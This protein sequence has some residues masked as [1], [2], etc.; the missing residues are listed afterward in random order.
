M[1][2]DEIM[3]MADATI[4]NLKNKKEIEVAKARKEELL[5]HY[6]GAD[7][8][9]DSG[10][11]AKEIAELPPLEM[12]STGFSTLDKETEGGFSP[13]QL[14]TITGIA[15]QGKTTFMINLIQNMKSQNPLFFSLEQTPDELIR[16]RM[17]FKREIPHFYFPADR[18]SKEDI[19]WI[20]EKILESIIKYG[21]KV[22]FIDHLDFIKDFVPSNERNDL[23]IQNVYNQL[24]R[25]A[26]KL[27]VCIVII[28][29]LKKVVIDKAPD[30]NDIADSRA[31]AQLSDKVIIV[32]REGK[33]D[34]SGKMTLTGVTNIALVADRQSG[35]VANLSFVWERGNYRELTNELEI[36][37]LRQSNLAAANKALGI[38]DS[39]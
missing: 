31:I 33:K 16:Q 32:W 34:I 35:N 20:E 36:D 21:T 7:R 9:I 6:A 14:I 5:K 2:I 13:Q 38:D 27:N 39:F 30:L 17:K 28:A 18:G 11:R 1:N 24:K 12:Y 15:K 8:I 23:Q 10:A 29:H 4:S 22:V 26:K 25:L 3:K 37:N 19:D